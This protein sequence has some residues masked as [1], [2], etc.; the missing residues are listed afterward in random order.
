MV[1]DS[2]ECHSLANQC[3]VNELSLSPVHLVYVEAEILYLLLSVSSLQRVL[4][5]D[6]AL[7]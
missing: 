1:G 7:K 4:Q 3:T 5:H 2:L 6:T